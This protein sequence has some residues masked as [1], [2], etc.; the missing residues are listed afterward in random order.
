MLIGPTE[1]VLYCLIETFFHLHF[2]LSVNFSSQKL[3]LDLFINLVFKFLNL[4]FFPPYN[5]SLLLSLGFI[6]FLTSWLNSQA[7]IMAT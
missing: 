1:C 7:C 3:P 5:K 4:P 6:P 2:Y